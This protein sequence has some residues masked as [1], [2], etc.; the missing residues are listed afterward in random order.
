MA[1][2]QQFVEELAIPLQHASYAGHFPGHP[3]VPGALL[4]RWLLLRVEAALPQWQVKQVVSIKF[5]SEV[6]PGDRLSLAGR[7]DEPTTR[8][9]LTVTRESHAVCTASLQMGSHEFS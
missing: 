3:L 4:L 8:L 7:F 9:S 1:A 5:R 6:H 2:P